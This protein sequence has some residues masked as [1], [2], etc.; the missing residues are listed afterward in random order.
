MRCLCPSS[1]RRRCAAGRAG[2]R[3]GCCGCWG[4]M[5][6]HHPGRWIAT[7]GMHPTPPRPCNCRRPTSPTPTAAIWMPTATPGPPTVSCVHS[8]SALCGRPGSCWHGLQAQAPSLNC[9]AGSPCRFSPADECEGNVEY[10]VG[11]KA[12]PGEA[13]PLPSV[14][15]QPAWCMR[16]AL[17]G[18]PQRA[19][20]LCGRPARTPPPPTLA[21]L[22]LRPAR[23][24][25]CIKACGRCADFFE[26]RQDA[27][28]VE[29]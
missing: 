1:R 9:P 8:L 13:T 29:L 6:V 21:P 15:S 12:R 24:G 3:L 26:F 18:A 17:A 19:R 27:Q 25:H 5:W 23:A 20:A 7:A 14:W 22:S 16:Q 10:M 2:R 11:S 4:A 28:H